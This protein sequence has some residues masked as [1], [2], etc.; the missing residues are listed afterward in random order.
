MFAVAMLVVAGFAAGMAI[1]VQKG[2]TVERRI[3]WTIWGVAAVALV[4]A[5]LAFALG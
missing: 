5:L 4:I 1:S 3:V 2:G